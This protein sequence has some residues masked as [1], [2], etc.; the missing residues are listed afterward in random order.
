MKRMVLLVLMWL[1]S[2]LSACALAQM[3][4]YELDSGNNGYFLC[5][6]FEGEVSQKAQEIFGDLMESGDEVICG[7]LFEERYR[8]RPEMTGRGGA[9]MAVRRDGKIL[10][11]SA[12]TN[13]KGWSAGIETDS[14]LPPDAAFS[15]NTELKNHFAHLMIYYDNTAYE[16]RTTGE[17]GA[18][19]YRYSWLDGQGNSLYMDCDRGMFVLRRK[20]AE[21]MDETMADAIAVPDRLAA[22]TADA[23]P[24]T[25]E[26]LL[27][28]EQA[29]PLDLQDDEAY[30]M[31]VNLRE[32][33]T[34]KSDTWGEYTAKVQ[35]LGQ[36]PGKDAPWYNVRVG[37]IEGWASGVYVHGK[38]A[39]NQRNV[40][41]AAIT[42]H[43]VGRA[44]RETAL[45]NTPGGSSFMTLASGSYVHILGERDGW[46]HVILP[47]NELT[48][49][50]DWDGRY[51]FV[52]AEDMAVGISKTDATY[53]D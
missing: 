8:S 37:N 42:I 14:F 52:K 6:D 28:F 26:S 50:T 5:E 38:N 36:K 10:L 12:N 13:G 51:G 15:L 25:A 3:G 35:I 30:I 53:K 32:D 49:Q 34:G 48:W 2:S 39:S 44:K 33:A 43:P 1:M 20:A 16:I 45:M 47:R 23:L 29:Y 24:K 21:G 18:Y 27:A 31:S 41:T 4:T 11:M 46:L 22:W 7:T 40:D 17:G 9:L 19:L